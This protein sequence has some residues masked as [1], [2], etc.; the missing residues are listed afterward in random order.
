MTTRSALRYEQQRNAEG[1]R[2]ETCFETTQLTYQPRFF[3][4]YS[5]E[6]IRRGLSR[7]VLCNRR[8]TRVKIVRKYCL[9]LSRI[10]LIL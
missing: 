9:E 7:H 6:V 2:M 5:Y 4:Y 8:T 3:V 1:Y 10:C